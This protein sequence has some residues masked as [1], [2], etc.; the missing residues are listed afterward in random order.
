MLDVSPMRWDDAGIIVRSKFKKQ[1][2][3]LRAYAYS[4]FSRI[5]GEAFWVL[6]GQVLAALGGVVGVRFLT[7]ALEPSKYGELSLGMT[8]AMFAMQ[9]L[10]PIGGASLRFFA[11]ANEKNQKEA[12]LQAL[13]FLLKRVTFLLLSFMAFVLVGLSLSGQEH[14]LP[15]V[16]AAFIFAL[17]SVYNYSLNGIQNAARQ[18]RVVAWHQALFQWLRF[19]SAIMLIYLLGGSSGTAMTGFAL[20]LLVVLISQ[21]MFLKHRIVGNPFAKRAEELD[22]WVKQMW[23]YAWPFMTWGMFTAVHL[24]SDRWA[25]QAFTNTQ[26]VGLYA[27][28]YQLGY[29]PMTLLSSFLMTFISPILFERAGDISNPLRVKVAQRLNNRIVVVC[30]ALTLC[31]S[32]SAFA[33]HKWVFG[34]LVSSQYSA[35]SPLLPWMV[36]A[37]GLFAS[38]QALSLLLLTELNS[39]GLIAPKIGTGILGMLL[40]I[41]GAYWLGLR[42]VVFATVVFSLIYLIWVFFLTRKRHV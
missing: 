26:Q 11:I 22:Y 31:A 8:F 24:I 27:V 41:S 32:I 19:L 18:R 1:G 6:A 36:L 23:T 9:I 39:K 12:F 2:F 10:G 17:F 3:F 38:G 16:S 37:G 7:E 40:N 42:G 4:K 15:L 14:F 30:I 28:L 25:L 35:V 13:I 29:Y 33:L 34:L 21:F 20:A 5:V